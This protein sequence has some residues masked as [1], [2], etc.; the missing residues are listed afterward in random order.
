MHYYDAQ[1]TSSAKLAGGEK[2]A[3]A[4]R[5]EDAARADYNAKNSLLQTELRAYCGDLNV[6]VRCVREDNAVHVECVCTVCDDDDV[7]YDDD[8]NDEDCCDCCC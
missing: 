3:A 5:A 4:E 2:A 6:D 7:V 1:R 8:V